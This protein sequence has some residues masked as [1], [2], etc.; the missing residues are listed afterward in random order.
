MRPRPDRLRHTDLKNW[1]TD[2]FASSWAICLA[3]L[4]TC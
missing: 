3:V 2:R 1:V 4:A